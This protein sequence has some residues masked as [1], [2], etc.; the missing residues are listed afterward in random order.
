MRGSEYR[1][2]LSPRNMVEGEG[3]CEKT[4]STIV[5]VVELSNRLT[6]VVRESVK[7]R[8]PPSPDTTAKARQLRAEST[9]LE[10]IVWGLLR[11]GKLGGLKFRRQHPIGPYTADFYCHEIGLI[12]EVDGASHEDRAEEDRRRTAY[13]EE[14]GLR[15]F[16]ITN[17]DVM[18]DPEAVARGIAIT[19]G[20]KLD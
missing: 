7:R 20:V 6:N 15:V 5:A 17:A 12:V 2:H 14:H 4:S 9:W 19:A 11:G 1:Y 3:A 10:K 18:S 16:R 13:L 8:H